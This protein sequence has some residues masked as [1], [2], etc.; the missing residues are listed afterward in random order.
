MPI[1]RLEPPTIQEIELRL[2]E[3]RAEYGLSNEEFQRNPSAVGDACEDE[4]CE[5]YLLLERRQVLLRLQTPE[6]YWKN[7]PVRVEYC[8]VRSCGEDRRSYHASVAA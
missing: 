7:T 1:K 4:M 5:W 8:S 3:L 6:E 2:G